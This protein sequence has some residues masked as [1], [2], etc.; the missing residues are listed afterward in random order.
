MRVAFTHSESLRS[1][2]LAQKRRVKVSSPEQHSEVH[3][4][5]KEAE[6]SWPGY[7]PFRKAK[8]AKE[9]WTGML[10]E[11]RAFK[12]ARFARTRRPPSAPSWR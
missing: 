10:K 8:E 11:V 9:S 1:P 5:A 2:P 3:Q 12:R 4:G 6:E 7:C